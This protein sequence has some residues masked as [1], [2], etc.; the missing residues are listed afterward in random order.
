MHVVKNDFL[1]DYEGI[2]GIDFLTKQ[3]AKCDHG[4]G[5]VR[6]IDKVN[7]K[8]HLFK[9]VTLTLRSET[10]VQAVTNRNRIGIVI[11]EETKLRVFIGSCLVEPEEYTCPISIINTTEESHR[12]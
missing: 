6:G 2:L 8:L 10:I 12:S 5:Q 4:K 11:S 3:R 9:K 7:F 1:I